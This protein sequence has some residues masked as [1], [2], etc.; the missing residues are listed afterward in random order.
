MCATRRGC[1]AAIPWSSSMRHCRCCA[2]S[3]GRCCCPWRR[4][5]SRR[6]YRR[7]AAAAAAHRGYVAEERETPSQGCR[8]SPRRRGQRQRC[9]LPPTPIVYPL[10]LPSEDPL[11]Q[12]LLLLLLHGY[13]R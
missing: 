9:R 10:L 12:M 6:L 5:C 4:G 8:C 2:L 3:E 7:A 13:E 11:L 1:I